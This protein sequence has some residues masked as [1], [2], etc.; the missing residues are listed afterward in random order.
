M[1]SLQLFLW[2]SKRGFY[3]GQT[4]I[5]IVSRDFS[6][7]SKSPQTQCLRA[8]SLELMSG[9]E[10]E[11]SSLPRWCPT[12]RKPA[13]LLG[14]RALRKRKNGFDPHFAHNGDELG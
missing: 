1:D 9:L 3:G 14:F 12:F 13:I 10:P 8:F 11:T 2:G 4:A 6:G 7:H 5:F